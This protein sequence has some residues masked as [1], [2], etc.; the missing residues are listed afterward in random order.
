M[1]AK[2][3]A[4]PAHVLV[5]DEPTNDLDTETL[6][7]L[8]ELLF[9]FKGTLLLV[10]HDRTFLNRVVTSI[11]VFEEDGQVREYA[12]GYDDWLVQRAESRPRPVPNGRPKPM[13]K[14]RS[15]RAL[16]LGFQEKRELA[17]LPARIQNLEAEQRNLFEAGA[18][19][20]FYKK[21]KDEVLRI[22]T[23]LARVERD[24]EQA[25]RRWEELD[26]KE[27]A[28]LGVGRDS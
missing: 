25:Y 13:A 28:V 24:I 16:K 12:G 20:F 15:P 27:Q 26:E 2:I 11:L 22:K 23:Q 7:L 6:E 10:S 18:D 9:D 14:A 5:L 21:G 17:E 4:R 3:F 1:L 19:P 8:E